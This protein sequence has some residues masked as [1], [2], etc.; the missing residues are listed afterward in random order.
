MVG[1]DRIRE[2]E[3]LCM[4]KNV[5][6]LS[7]KEACKNIFLGICAVGDSVDKVIDYFS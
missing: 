4:F 7:L 1:G 5:P 3:S 6:I 2:C